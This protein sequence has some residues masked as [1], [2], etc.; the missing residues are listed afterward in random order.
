[1]PTREKVVA[2]MQ[3][4]EELEKDLKRA[5]DIAFERQDDKRTRELLYVRQACENAR[6]HLGRL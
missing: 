1:M 5:W 2:C 3:A 4:L 6:S